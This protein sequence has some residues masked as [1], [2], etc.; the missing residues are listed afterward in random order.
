MSPK[1]FKILIYNWNLCQ[2]DKK[3]V[4]K[5]INLSCILFFSEKH[6]LADIFDFITFFL[7]VLQ[8]KNFVILHAHNYG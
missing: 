2:I 3:L 4:G 8:R 6:V 1:M 5:L 7:R